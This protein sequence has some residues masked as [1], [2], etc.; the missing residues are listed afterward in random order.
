MTPE[1]AVLHFSVDNSPL[2][3]MWEINYLNEEFERASNLT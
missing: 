3:V 1:E 2:S